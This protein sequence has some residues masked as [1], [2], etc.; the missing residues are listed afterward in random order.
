MPDLSEVEVFWRIV[1]A[2]GLGA[3]VGIER[4][5]AG[6]PAGLRTHILICAASA[7]LMFLG[8]GIVAAFEVGDHVVGADPIRIMQAIVIGISFLGAGT[9]IHG[10]DRDVE[11]LTTASSI[12]LIAGIGMA[13]AIDRLFLAVATT[14]FALVVLLLIGSIERL[15]RRWRRKAKH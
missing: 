8:A 5:V 6:K 15:V 13:V 12:L 3:L 9:I 4:E 1:L 14:C 7:M 10:G 11:G 2:G